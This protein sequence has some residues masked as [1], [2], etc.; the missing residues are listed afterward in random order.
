MLILAGVV[1]VVL[2]V[3]LVIG[4]IDEELTVLP[5][6]LTSTVVGRAGRTLVG[7]VVRAVV[8][9]V[10]AVGAVRGLVVT[11]V[12]ACIGPGGSSAGV[13]GMGV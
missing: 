5:L 11:V 9:E 4:V 7:T 3:R 1:L 2:E 8:G 12:G 6:R 13:T 10:V